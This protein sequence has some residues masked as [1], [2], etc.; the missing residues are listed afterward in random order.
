M[1]SVANEI[2]A[3]PFAIVGSIGVVTQIPNF[4]RFLEKHDVDA[5]L[6]TSGKYKRTVDIIGEVTEEGKQKLQEQLDDIH[7]AFKDHVALSRAKLKESIE[8]VVT[9]EYWLAVQAKELG[10]VDQIMTSDELLDHL[11]KDKQ[12][13]V[14]EII[15]KKDK[16]HLISQFFTSI[17]ANLGLFNRFQQQQFQSNTPTPMAIS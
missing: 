14:I 7:G 5:Y 15:Q 2:Y 13:D 9:G 11:V 10:L 3:A 6:F 12:N 16:A 4:H 17:T 1:A 8:D